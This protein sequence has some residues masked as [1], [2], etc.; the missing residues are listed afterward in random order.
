MFCRRT[1]VLANKYIYSRISVFVSQE[2]TLIQ[3]S[4][5]SSL[6]T[7]KHLLESQVNSVFPRIIFQVPCLQESFLND[8]ISEVSHRLSQRN[9]W[10]RLRVGYWFQDQISDFRLWC[11]SIVYA[12]LWLNGTVNAGLLS[13]DYHCLIH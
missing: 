3:A 6:V 9:S 4:F 12:G 5:S 2:V 13:D 10:C 11:M 8:A 1:C 7:I